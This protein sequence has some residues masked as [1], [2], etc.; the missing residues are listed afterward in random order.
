MA[1]IYDDITALTGNTPLVRINRLTEGIDTNLLAKLEYYNPGNSVKDR[2]AGYIHWKSRANF[3]QA[4]LICRRQR[5]RVDL[6]EVREWCVVEAGLGAF[7]ELL[8]RL[9][10]V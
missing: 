1:L 9:D 3:D 8:A 4:L 2:L 10:E 5:I 6:N 7:G